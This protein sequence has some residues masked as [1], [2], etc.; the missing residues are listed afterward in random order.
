[1]RVTRRYNS[2]GGAF[3]YVVEDVL[4]EE[5]IFVVRARDPIGLA[6]IEQYRLMAGALL[7]DER[8][9]ELNAKRDEFISFGRGQLRF[10]D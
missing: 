5:P 1:M 8:L 3:E 10:P 9:N 4:P 2:H 6:I 7:S